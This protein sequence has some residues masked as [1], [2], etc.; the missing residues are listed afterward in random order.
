MGKPV[1]NLVKNQK[2]NGEKPLLANWLKI[3]LI[4]KILKNQYVKYSQVAD[5]N[6]FNFFLVL[7]T[8][9]VKIIN[10]FSIVFSM[11]IKC[12]F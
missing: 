7:L 12:D 1:D 9:C 10:F 6:F 5:V 3:H 8:G 11:S 2:N 4:K